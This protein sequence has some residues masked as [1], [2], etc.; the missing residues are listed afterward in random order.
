MNKNTK[1]IIGAAIVIAVIAIGYSIKVPSEPTETGPIKIGVIAPLSGKAAVWGETVRNGI[2]LALEQIN[3]K[4]GINGRQIQVIYEDDQ[5]DVKNTISAFNKLVGIDNVVAIIGPVGSGNAKVV[6]P[7]FKERKV[8]TILSVVGVSDITRN[9]DYIFRIWPSGAMKANKMKEKLEKSGYKKIAIISANNESPLDLLEQLK[10]NVFP[11]V[12]IEISI[13][14]TV[15]KKET[16]FRTQLS[17]IKSAEF[18]ALFV[19]LYV[20][21][22]GLGIKQARELGITAPIFSSVA[23]DSQKELEMAGDAMEGVWFPGSPV[24]SN[25]FLQAY[26]EKF[27]IDSERGAPSSYDA[28]MFYAKAIK[29]AGIDREEIIREL[30]RIRNYEGAFSN[31]SFDSN[32]DANINLPL[33]IIKDGEFVLLK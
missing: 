1:W 10:D 29:N 21:Q 19:N 31:I 14:D 20:N 25:D 23:A 32:G 6:A 11:D 30:R 16:D 5:F 3:G 2:E 13:E 22:I 9:N 4:G 17:K 12:G 26:K 28:L 7:L 24:P 27:G 8:P 15:D 18:D 33:K